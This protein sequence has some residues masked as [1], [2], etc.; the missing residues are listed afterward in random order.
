MHNYLGQ[1]ESIVKNNKR[2]INITTTQLLIK[3][4]D[5]LEVPSKRQNKWDYYGLITL[6]LI[7]G[8]V[9]KSRWAN[10]GE[11]SIRI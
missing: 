8:T 11:I 5:A 2:N 7:P 6:T 4:D 10:S 9:G 3:S 1:Y